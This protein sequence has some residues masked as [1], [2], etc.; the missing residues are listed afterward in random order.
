[1]SIL[2][3]KQY[4]KHNHT[5]FTHEIS[6]TRLHVTQLPPLRKKSVLD[7]VMDHWNKAVWGGL[8]T[9]CGVTKG[10]CFRYRGQVSTDRLQCSAVTLDHCYCIHLHCTMQLLYN[11]GQCN[12]AIREMHNSLPGINDATVMTQK[13]SI[14]QITSAHLAMITRVRNLSPPRTMFRLAVA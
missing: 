12:S 3:P 6:S 8:R 9:Q 14:P 2:T 11:Q 4:Y 13:K 5:Q 7:V 10:W 1:M